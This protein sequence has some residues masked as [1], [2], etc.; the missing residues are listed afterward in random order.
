MEMVMA[1]APSASSLSGAPSGPAR[2]DSGGRTLMARKGKA[3]EGCW[4]LLLSTASSMHTTGTCDGSIPAL[5][6]VCTAVAMWSPVTMKV[7][8]AASRRADI[9]AAVPSLMGALIAAMPISSMR[10]S[11][12]ARGRSAAWPSASRYAAARTTHLAP[13]D[14]RRCSSW[15][16]ASGKDLHLETSATLSGLPLQTTT[17]CPSGS[18]TTAVLLISCAQGNGPRAPTLQ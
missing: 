9:V 18:C 10:A 16:N 8:I 17:C 5:R 4:P 6:A 15:E 2:S 1:A 11:S 3:A 13:W 14:M 12:S 7:R